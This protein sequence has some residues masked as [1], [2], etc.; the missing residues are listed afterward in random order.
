MIIPEA[1]ELE[2]KILGTIMSFP[3][4]MPEIAVILSSEMFFDPKNRIIYSNLVKS[5]DNNEALDFYSIA[6]HHKEQ[7]DI[8]ISYLSSLLSLVGSGVGVL[9]NCLIVKEKYIARELSTGSYKIYCLASE[10]SNDIQDVINESNKINDR[11]NEILAGGRNGSHISEVVKKSLTEA[12]KRQI[13][14]S[15]GK[16]NGITT[17]LI[18]MD[19][20]LGGWQKSTLNILAARPSI[21]KTAC[22]LH[23][24]KA[25]AKSGS[26]GCIYSLEMSDVSLI[27]RMLLS[28]C[29]VDIDNFKKGRLTSE[30]W[31]KLEQ[32]GSELSK[33]PIYV[34][35]NPVVSMRY[36]KSHSTVMNRK[37]KCEWIMI[38]YLQLAETEKSGTREQ[39]ISKA[40]RFAKIIAKELKIPIILLSQLSRAVEARQDKKPNLS[41]LRESGAIEQDA[42]T[43]TFIYRPKYYGIDF[44]FL[45]SEQRDVNMSNFGQ[46]LIAKQRDGAIGTVNFLHNDS[47]TQ[48]FDYSKDKHEQLINKSHEADTP[49]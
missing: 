49:F 9:D 7:N 15:E 30:E 43:V 34:D 38:D 17:G 29:D 40:S 16:T 37:G 10:P 44:A 23:F 11:I 21:G 35:D 3:E 20:I 2:K 47:M 45:K 5:Y 14:A 12:E 1:I 6:Q 41:D 48:I 19:A 24:A 27:N 8:E 31:S 28:C 26:P 42:D 18:G 4:M 25:A 33:L 39:E 36:I 13:R 32:A 46:F 22:L